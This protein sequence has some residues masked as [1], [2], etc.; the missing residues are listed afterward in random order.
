MT[1]D[2]KDKIDAASKHEEGETRTIHRSRPDT[3]Y[4]NNCFEMTDEGS[5]NDA[6]AAASA[7]PASSS[8]GGDGSNNSERLSE[9]GGVHASRDGEPTPAH[10]KCIDKVTTSL[11]QCELLCPRQLT[12]FSRAF[13]TSDSRCSGFMNY[14]KYTYLIFSP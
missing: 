4:C 12:L 2:L 10:I 13:M 11:K 5:K 9:T 3:R 1:A 14:T 6:V 7:S 8:G